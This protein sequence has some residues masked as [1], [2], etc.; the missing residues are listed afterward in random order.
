MKRFFHPSHR[1][2]FIYEL[3]DKGYTHSWIASIV[4]LERSTVTY[5]LSKP[6]PHSIE[7]PSRG[8]RMSTQN[9]KQAA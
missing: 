1:L 9:L 3:R 8:N 2:L 4:G 6:R 7:I 5:H